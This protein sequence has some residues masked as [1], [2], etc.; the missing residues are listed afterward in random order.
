MDAFSDKWP[1]W[2][3]LTSTA[4]HRGALCFGPDRGR[5]VT[6]TNPHRWLPGF[7]PADA[8]AALRTLV[9]RYLHAY[10]PATPQH[11]ARWL[12][13]P[14]RYAAGL[15]GDLADELECVELD[16]RPGWTVAGDPASWWRSLPNPG[17][18]RLAGH[19]GGQRAAPPDLA[20]NPA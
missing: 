7:R 16:G 18:V 2:R 12:G 4:A 19:M 3:Q 11:F 5:Q 9:T 10:G 13:I 1:R 17:A 6:Y 8:E 20:A 15:F 14:P